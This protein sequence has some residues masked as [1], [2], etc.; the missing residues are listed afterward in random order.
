MRNSAFIMQRA[1]DRA[2]GKKNRYGPENYNQSP[3]HLMVIVICF[4]WLWFI[5]TLSHQ[6]KKPHFLIIIYKNPHV[7]PLHPNYG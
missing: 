1:C 7:H 2:N 4:T 6:K 5:I 3:L